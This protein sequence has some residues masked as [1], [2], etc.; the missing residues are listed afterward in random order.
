M[1]IAGF[2]LGGLIFGLVSTNFVNPD[3]INSNVEKED[4]VTPEDFEFVPFD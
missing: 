4:K 1:I 3:A 2:G